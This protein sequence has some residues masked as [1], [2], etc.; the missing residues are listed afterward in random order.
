MTI[1]SAFLCFW[2][3]WQ[4]GGV[5]GQFLYCRMP[6]TGIWCFPCDYRL[7]IWALGRKI[8]VKECHFHCI[9]SKVHTTK[10]I[11]NCTLTLSE[12]CA[13]QVSLLLNYSFLHFLYSA[14]QKKITMCCLH[15]RSGE[16]RSICLKGEQPHKLF[17]S[18]HEI[19]P[20]C[21]TYL[22][23]HLLIS[24]QTHKHYTAGYY[25]LLFYFVVQTAASLAT[26]ALSDGPCPFH[27]FFF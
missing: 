15:L 14:L 22:F 18:S 21:P 17:G 7:W 11:Y 13:C 9:I 6:D 2:W 27:D 20:F 12:V 24:A 19:C 4:C 23:T 26:R 5:L 25:P 8:T 1:S 16:L 3:P 10:L